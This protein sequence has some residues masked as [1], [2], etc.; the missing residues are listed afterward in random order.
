[1]KVKRFLLLTIGLVV[2]FLAVGNLTAQAASTTVPQK[3]RGTFYQYAG[4]KKWDKLVIKRHSAQL[5]GPDYSKRAFKLTP[6]AKSKAHKL[7]FKSEGK[8]E[9]QT[10]FRLDSKLEDSS[11]SV[12]PG[13]GLSLATRKIKGK[14]YK[15][16][17]GFQGGYWFDFIKG[18]KLT[19]RYSGIANGKY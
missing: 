3:F 4:H 2:A 8:A 19:H 10:F 18:H 6:N 7:S 11:R 5:S 13:N 1:M 17:R 15:V 16:V 12:F 14:R 9:H